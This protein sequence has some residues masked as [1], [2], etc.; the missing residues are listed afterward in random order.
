MTTPIMTRTVDQ[1]LE[2]LGG[3]LLQT[4]LLSEAE[5]G[6]LIEHSTGFPAGGDHRMFLEYRLDTGLSFEGYG[7][8]YPLEV[9]P[10]LVK[11]GLEPEI[12]GRLWAALA[13]DPFAEDRH[14]YLDLTPDPDPEW[15]EYDYTE[16][17][18]A[19]Q[20]GVF[21]R[22]P[23][24]FQRLDTDDRVSRL[25]AALADVLPAAPSGGAA[26]GDLLRALVAGAAPDGD[27]I[28]LYRL[29]RC[30]AR[31][32]GWLRIIA[33]GLRRDGLGALA[34]D[35][36]APADPDPVG[37]VVDAMAAHGDQDPPIAA[38]VTVV[39]GV[40]TAIDLECGYLNRRSDPALRRGA[41]IA[42]CDGLAARGLVSPAIAALIAGAAVSELRVADGRVGGR[43][44]LNHV[45]LGVVG[46]TTGRAK[47]YFE[48]LLRDAD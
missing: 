18:F 21:F 16:A 26:L 35:P 7:H 17:G 28:G 31:Q 5:L 23:A 29:G 40:V 47:A 12:A 46:S 36:L 14:R 8:G 43:L 25:E 19:E 9:L 4:G 6:R 30:E 27:G 44:L 39:D 48:L 41:A 37:W 20:P 2:P 1:L 38:S 10:G 22:F 34:Q 45:K 24:R 13:E 15:I 33:N 42:I 32:P 11:S 3:Q